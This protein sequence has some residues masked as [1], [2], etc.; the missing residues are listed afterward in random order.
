MRWF[1]LVVFLIFVSLFSW[2]CQIG[3]GQYFAFV[4]LIL[5]MVVLVFLSQYIH[6]QYLAKP[7]SRLWRFT[8]WVRCALAHEDFGNEHRREGGKEAK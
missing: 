2:Y 4:G 5:G 7:Q 1:V 3:W 6:K 8:E